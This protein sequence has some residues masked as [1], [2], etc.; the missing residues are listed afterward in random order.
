[1]RARTQVNTEHVIEHKFLSN[2][3]QPFASNAYEYPEKLSAIP[4]I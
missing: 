3:T 4:V 2:R 1:M